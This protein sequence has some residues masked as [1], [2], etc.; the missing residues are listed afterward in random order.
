MDKTL[1]CQLVIMVCRSAV[2]AIVLA[3]YRLS[4][5]HVRWSTNITRSKASFDLAAVHVHDERGQFKVGLVSHQEFK[6]VGLVSILEDD[7]T[8]MHST[9]RFTD[10]RS[11]VH[12]SRMAL[13]RQP[14]KDVSSTGFNDL[15]AH[16]TVKLGCS[17]ELFAN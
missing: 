6:V 3:L 5:Q 13:F 17:L 15:Q 16:T 7:A 4:L 1:T 12:I 8:G 9:V 14:I 2:I 11:R 10:G